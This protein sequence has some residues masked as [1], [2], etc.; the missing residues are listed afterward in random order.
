MLNYGKLCEDCYLTDREPATGR[1]IPRSDP[2]SDRR[3]AVIFVGVPIL[4]A[5][6]W[7]IFAPLMAVFVAWSIRDSAQGLVH[8]IDMRLSGY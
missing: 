2:L 1:A 4:I 3:G 7:I 6:L 5:I 8:A